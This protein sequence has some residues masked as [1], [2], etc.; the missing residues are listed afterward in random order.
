MEVTKQM[1]FGRTN[2]QKP[3]FKKISDYV[4]E[5]DKSFKQGMRVPARVYASRKILD[6]M[7]LQVY[8]QLTNVATLPGIVDH[9]LCMPDGHFSR[10]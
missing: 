4:W 1:G 9:A 2:I 8:D 6:G 10:N 3:N 7:D 5:V